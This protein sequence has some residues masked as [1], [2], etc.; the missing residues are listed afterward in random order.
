MGRPKNCWSLRVGAAGNAVTVYE[1]RPGGALYLRWW[2]AR[3][4]ERPNGKWEK[5]AL[6]HDDRALGE[7]TARD[8]AAQLL[9]ST[10]AAAV[11]KAT[12]GEVFT[13]Y[14]RDVCSHQ[15]GQGPKEAKRRIAIWSFFLGA[16][17]EVQ[18][19]D[20]PT[21][22]RFVR[23]RRAGTI[24]PPDHELP[25]S[26]GNRA[27]GADLE[28][29]RAALNHA[30]RVVR[31]SG[32]RLLLVNPVAGYQVPRT[33]QPRRPVVT[34]DRFL[35]VLEHADVIDPQRLF[36]GF[37]M[38]VEGL[39]WRVS[40]IC[41]LL[42]AHVDLT[43]S[44]VAP[45]GRI[46]KNP[47]ADKE[48]AGGWIPMSESVHAAVDRI[49]AVNP[50]IGDWPMFP[51]PKAR[52]SIEMVAAVVAEPM[53]QPS[54]ATAPR[55][56]NKAPEIPKAWSRHHARKLL[57]RAEAKAKLPEIDGSDFHAYRRK[58]ATER[59][60]LP[61]Q[62]VAHAGAWLDIKTLQTAY[63]QPDDQ[64]VLSVVNE[65]TKLRDAKPKSETA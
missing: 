56:A 12:V 58:W 25:K 55:P 13:A 64:T 18:S 16:T 52:R 19:I 4:P 51:A 59:K 36:G 44:P 48:G 28:F 33:K 31:P 60:H 41:A 3:S 17:R 49:R 53:I 37:M 5:R 42:A 10:M 27:V 39:G 47:A 35:K 63:T 54:A 46:F 32:E 30:C 26:P 8:V 2:L 14:E 15:K 11:G 62:D 45:R 65:P 40:A 22:D 21:L 9:A 20:Y 57:S 50:A 23:E 7:K 38:L 34:Y 29:L 6:K 1:R 43:E 24:Q 61:V